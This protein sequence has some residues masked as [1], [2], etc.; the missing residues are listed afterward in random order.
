MSKFGHSPYAYC[1]I[2]AWWIPKFG[3]WRP[4]AQGKTGFCSGQC[5]QANGRGRTVYIWHKYI[6]AIFWVHFLLT[7]LQKISAKIEEKCESGTFQKSTGWLS[8]SCSRWTNCPG[9]PEGHSIQQPFPSNSYGE[10][11]KWLPAPLKSHHVKNK[12][13]ENFKQKKTIDLVKW[14]FAAWKIEQL[15]IHSSV[16]SNLSNIDGKGHKVL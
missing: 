16:A 9:V 2:C 8:T 10:S 12:T 11:Y 4:N 13:C 5:V 15:F 3:H 1:L 6:S 7:G 14:W